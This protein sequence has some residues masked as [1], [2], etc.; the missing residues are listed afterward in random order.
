M[1]LFVVALGFWLGLCV[2]VMSLVRH[3]YATA[4]VVAGYTVCRR[5]DRPWSSPRRPSSTS[6]PAPRR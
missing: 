1:L 6:S 2:G 5:W 4:A 3:F